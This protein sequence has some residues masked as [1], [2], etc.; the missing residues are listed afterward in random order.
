MGETALASPD[1][2]LAQCRTLCDFVNRWNS[3][4]SVCTPMKV[5]GCWR[6]TAT[7]SH[8]WH[9]QAKRMYI[10]HIATQLMD[11]SR[12]VVASSSPLLFFSRKTHVPFFGLSPW[13][14]WTRAKKELFQLLDKVI[15]KRQQPIPSQ[16]S[17]ARNG[18]SSEAIL[19]LSICHSEV[20]T[21]V[22]LVLRLH[23]MK[24]RLY[25]VRFSKDLNS[26]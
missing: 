22:V 1:C 16:S 8:E 26:N 14:R 23:R 2:S 11:A 6:G 24:W 17:F 12:R 25:S 19:R 4:S 5:S 9:S 18:L 13:D 7:M 10:R 20:G 21:D 3:H 15:E